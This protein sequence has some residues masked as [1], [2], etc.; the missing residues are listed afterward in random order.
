MQVATHQEAV[1]ALRNAG[2]FI[3]MT[4]LRDRLLHREVSDLGGT[5][6]QQ[7]VIGRQLCSLDGKGQSV[8]Q[9]TMENA[10]RFLSRKIEAVICN[11]NGIVSGFLKIPPLFCNIP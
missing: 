9:S 7:A 6:D 1:S 5:Q 10:D 4:V 11:G 3:K 8:K 2:S